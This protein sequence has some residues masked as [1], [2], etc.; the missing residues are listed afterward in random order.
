MDSQVRAAMIGAIATVLAAVIGLSAL[1]FA[2]SDKP[3]SSATDTTTS[4]QATRPRVVLHV[5][6]H[7]PQDLALEVRRDLVSRGYTVPPVVDVNRADTPSRI[8]V[9]Y[10][11]PLDLS[12]A[13][14]VV[15][16]LKTWNITAVASPRYEYQGTA[17]LNQVEVWFPHRPASRKR[18]TG[19]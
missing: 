3:A 9:R 14:A 11:R 17:P 13:E 19:T 18:P 16:D 6:L 1:Y 4:V 12:M 2:R 10:F 8:E 7:D 15:D 5:A